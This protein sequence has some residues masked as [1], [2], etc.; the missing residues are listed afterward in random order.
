MKIGLGG[1][2]TPLALGGLLIASVLNG[3]GCDDDDTTTGAAGTGGGA[4]NAG[5][6]GG[7]GS[8]GS[9]GT[10]GNAGGG[11]ATVTAYALTLTGGGEVAPVNTQAT[12]SVAVMLDASDNVTVTGTFTGLTSDV[13]VA[14]IHGPASATMTAEPIVDLTVSPGRAG[15]VSGSGQLT[16]SEA[17]AMRSGMTYINIHSSTNTAGEIRAQIQ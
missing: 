1:L 15:T 17:A 6:M 4:G 16:A 13:T 11:G 5:A 3:T 7:A 8:T 10:T 9:A 2:I 14:H 12:A